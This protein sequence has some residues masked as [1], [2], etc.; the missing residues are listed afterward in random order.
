MYVPVT[1]PVTTMTIM[2]VNRTITLLFSLSLSSLSPTTTKPYPHQKTPTT[3]TGYRKVVGDTCEGG[4]Q[5]QQAS[6]VVLGSA[7]C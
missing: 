5:P 1:L 7:W 3:Q 6:Q 4:W 2:I